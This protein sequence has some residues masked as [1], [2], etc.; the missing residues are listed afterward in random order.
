MLRVS[1]HRLRAYENAGLIK[2]ERL[3]TTSEKIQ[4]GRRMYSEEDIQH[5]RNIKYFI[6][7]GLSILAIKIILEKMTPEELL[8]RL[9]SE[10]QS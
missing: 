4:V 10:N 7:S 8:E 2:T 5:L 6:D 9:K 3:P 1:T